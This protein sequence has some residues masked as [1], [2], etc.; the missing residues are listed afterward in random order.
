M[1]DYGLTEFLADLDDGKAKLAELGGSN[2][3]VE[4]L[5]FNTPQGPMLVVRVIAKDIG[6]MTTYHRKPPKMPEILRAAAE[7]LGYEATLEP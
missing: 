6:K 2:L 7:A 1:D 3:S 4:L 5:D